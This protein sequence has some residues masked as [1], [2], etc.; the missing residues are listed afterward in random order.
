MFSYS[1]LCT[2]VCSS[3]D[4]T[5]IEMNLSLRYL[6]LFNV[7]MC[8]VLLRRGET[9]MSIKTKITFSWLSQN[10]PPFG[11]KQAL[12]SERSRSCYV[13]NTEYYVLS[14]N[15]CFTTASINPAQE[16]NRSREGKSSANVF[17]KS[18]KKWPG[19]SAIHSSSSPPL[20]H[21]TPYPTPHPPPPPP[22]SGSGGTICSKFLPCSRRCQLKYLS[23]DCFEK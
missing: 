2:E 9:W 19:F 1:S 22:I 5:V 23:S 17:K 11:E 15:L 6:V 12:L 10:L 7:K 20:S 8:L 18:H 14:I 21:P 4:S 3:L 16:R 13:R